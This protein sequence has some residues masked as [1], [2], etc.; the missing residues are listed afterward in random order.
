MNTKRNETI[1]EKVAYL[2]SMI[3]EM[4]EDGC[5]NVANLFAAELQTTLA[6]AKFD[7]GELV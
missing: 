3:D 2:K 5:H 7:K 6:M 1:E 4:R